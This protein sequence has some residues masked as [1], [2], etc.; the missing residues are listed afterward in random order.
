MSE[1]AETIEKAISDGEL[2]QKL[3]QKGQ[4]QIKK[5]SWEKMAAETL[6]IY[7]KSGLHQK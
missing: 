7:S 3:I 1:M 4:E 6:E 2:R 5:F